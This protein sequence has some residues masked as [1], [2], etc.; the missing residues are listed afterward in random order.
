MVTE[1]RRRILGDFG[2]NDPEHW[3]WGGSPAKDSSAKDNPKR[4]DGLLLVFAGEVGAA[5]ALADELAGPAG[6][7]ELEFVPLPEPRLLRAAPREPAREHFGFVDGVGNPEIRGAGD[8]RLV[9]NVVAPGEFL[10]GYPNESGQLPPSPTVPPGGRGGHVLP[11]GDLGRNGSYLVL[12]QLEQHARAFWTFL[13]ERGGGNEE[14]AIRLAAK[15]VGRWRNGA[16]LA[17]W[18]HAEPE[19]DRVKD[20]DFFYS[21]DPRGL[22]CPLGAHVRRANPRD[23]IPLLDPAGSLDLSK[24]RRI[25][26]RGRAYG[27]P[28]DGWPEPAKIAASNNPDVGRGLHFLCFN[29]DLENQFEF[30]QQTWVNSRKFA[31]LVNDADPLLS[32]AE[33]PQQAGRTDFTI[34]D[35]R[36]SRRMRGLPQFVETRGGEYFFMPGRRALRFLAHL[37]A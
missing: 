19:A 6:G 2:K 24:R 1:H 36:G 21:L 18:P 14:Q 13:L 7:A 20:D 17:K 4:A 9:H 28:L 25:L 5:R 23:A 3:E 26:R 37:G 8:P 11:K 10:L 30:V 32:N 34:Q 15:L 16:P 33:W 22:A 27:E 35:A 12:R 29:T 31:G